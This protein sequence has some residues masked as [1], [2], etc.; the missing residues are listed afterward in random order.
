[1]G[2]DNYFGF[3]GIVGCG[4]T[5]QSKLFA[6]ELKRINPGVEV[7]WTFEPGGHSEIA[8]AIRKLVQG[9]AFEERMTERT[10]A[11][12]YAAARAQ[13]LPTEV[14]P[15]LDRG[16]FVVSDR[17]VDSSRSYQGY[18]RGVGDD[19]VK[20]INGDAVGDLIPGKVAVIDVP[21]AVGWARKKDK[22]G[23]KFDSM[24]IEFF[25]RV[26]D[27]YLKMAEEEPERL[28]VVDG[29][30][31]VEEVQARVCQALLGV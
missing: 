3:E 2:K 16:G 10:E 4:K 19:L 23:D 22:L 13:T 26:R 1:M 17:T 8:L 18:G 6:K 31:T 14:E 5:T 7:L 11:Y 20:R 12:L 30:G 27:G 29:V 25:E 21:P 28:L 15:V 24:G 9:T